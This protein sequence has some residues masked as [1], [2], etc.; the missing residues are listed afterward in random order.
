MSRGH[1]F[2]TRALALPIAL[3][4]LGMAIPALVQRLAPMVSGQI[5]LARATRHDRELFVVPL[6]NPIVWPL[7]LVWRLPDQAS[8]DIAGVVLETEDGVVLGPADSM[9]EDIAAL[10]GGRFSIWRGAAYVSVPPE[11]VGKSLH[12]KGRGVGGVWP[13][14]A[15]SAL[16]VVAV[17]IGWRSLAPADWRS[18]GR[19]LAPPFVLAL[20]GSAAWLLLFQPAFM[21]SDSSCLFMWPRSFMGH[22][23]AVPC[24]I[25]GVLQLV[26]P[27]QLVGIAWITIGA[28]LF[29]AAIAALAAC[30]E[31][32][33]ARAACVAVPFLFGVLPTIGLGVT[34]D[35]GAVAGGLL[36]AAA[37]WLLYRDGLNRLSAAIILAAI[38]VESSSRHLAMAL[39]AGA[40]LAAFLRPGPWGQRLGGAGASVAALA[41][42][43]LLAS[44]VQSATAALSGAR[45]ESR[46]GR[47][48][49][50][51]LARVAF[52]AQIVGVTGDAFIES[53]ASA[54]AT[55]VVVRRASAIAA[56]QAA[57]AVNAADDAASQQALATRL[58]SLGDG[59]FRWL[60]GG[61]W[62]TIVEPTGSCTAVELE[63]AALIAYFES[64]WRQ[65]QG[66]LRV[67]THMLSFYASPTRGGREDAV[68]LRKSIDRAV[69]AE[70]YARIRPAFAPL[71]RP[72]A[73]EG[74]P[75]IPAGASVLACA[76]LL[77]VA[78]CIPRLRTVAPPAF[79]FAALCGGALYACGT[80]FAILWYKPTYAAPM[81]AM[82]VGVLAI[83]VAGA[84]ERQRRPP[85]PASP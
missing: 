18:F 33:T 9:H 32:R 17:V 70:A 73:R 68:E 52:G 56:E 29:S 13:T 21:G 5:D 2:V 16:C 26:L 43:V 53:L 4:L 6:D 79:V 31:S 46:P 8:D 77:A 60:P 69:D 14:L 25:A 72:D 64:V 20:A 41:L 45:F 34:A 22:W 27:M 24:A 47:A 48:A 65:P 49:A 66:W 51:S 55:D 61:V 12:W 57:S 71:V 50:E 81:W 82:F 37:L 3:A 7:R 40:P 58:Q 63:R 23:P 39:L 44:Q 15:A 75:A 62:T 76:L 67:A 11:H 1:R 19:R 36:A 42:S 85:H 59:V 80:V 84:L 54:G 10:G 78:L 83:V 30:F 38:L 28:L 74:P 35:A